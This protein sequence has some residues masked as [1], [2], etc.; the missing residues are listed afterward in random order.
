MI[1]ISAG[2]THLTS[3]A[4]YG[5]LFYEHREAIAW[6]NILCSLLGATAISVPIGTLKNKVEFIKSQA[7]KY[8]NNLA[9]EVHFNSAK[10]NG[11]YVGR[12]CETLHYPKSKKGILLATKVQK[13]MV[14]Y[15][16]PDRGIKEGYYQMNPSKPV[17][18]FLSRTPCPSIII[19]PDFVHR[20]KLIVK[21]RQACCE[22][23]ANALGGCK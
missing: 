3:G 15:F 1:F 8:S 17:D 14:E 23:I 13:A 16:E 7:V 19:E 2:H 18:Y 9:I 11:E 20:W 21:H 10:R 4:S 6:R 5:D 12:G 22:S